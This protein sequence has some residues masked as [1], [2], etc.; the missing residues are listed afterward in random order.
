MSNRS[1]FQKWRRQVKNK[2]KNS[3]KFYKKNSF[4]SW[5]G[6][7]GVSI[8]SSTTTWCSPMEY[9]VLLYAAAYW[10]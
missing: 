10:T 8:S 3:W 1:R 6:V 9:F 7:P 5:T 4:R 2:F